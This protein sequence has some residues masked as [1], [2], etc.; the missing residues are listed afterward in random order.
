M[1]LKSRYYR[2]KKHRRTADKKTL[3]PND[4]DEIYSQFVSWLLNIEE[5]DQMPYE[6]NYL[7]LNFSFKNNSINLSIS[8]H[9]RQP[10][11]IYNGSYFPLEAQ[12]FN[13]ELLNAF[14]N[15]G[16]D[17]KAKESLFDIFLNFVKKMKTLPQFK[18]LSNKNILIG[19]EYN[20]PE[21]SYKF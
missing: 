14:V 21:F 15:R 12:F 8:G 16:F 19:E 11:I 3:L 20:P 2:I 13:C 9:E 18:Y 10:K 5:D 6:I 7:C 1:I 4:I 17:I